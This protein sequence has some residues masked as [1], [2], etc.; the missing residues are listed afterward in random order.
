MVQY[1]NIWSSETILRQSELL[2]A[3]EGRSVPCGLWPPQLWA[4]VC[5]TGAE[6]ACGI[7]VVHMLRRHPK[8]SKGGMGRYGMTH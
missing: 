6:R 4:K 1:K 8:P 3:V 7:P 2:S 5:N